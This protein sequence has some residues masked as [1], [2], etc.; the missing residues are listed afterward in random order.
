[1]RGKMR[2]LCKLPARLSFALKKSKRR[3]RGEKF[4]LKFASGGRNLKK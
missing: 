2:R 3:L 4:P 1:M